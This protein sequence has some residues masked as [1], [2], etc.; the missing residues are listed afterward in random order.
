[1]LDFAHTVFGE[2]F[3]PDSVIEKRG[4]PRAVVDSS[5][6]APVMATSCPPDPALPGRS[7]GSPPRSTVPPTIT[8]SRRPSSTNYST[9]QQRPALPRIHGEM[10]D[11]I[12]RHP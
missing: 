7:T 3:E 2:R 5:E 12:K 4:S 6:V 9:L 1:M 11:Q 8:P 10:L